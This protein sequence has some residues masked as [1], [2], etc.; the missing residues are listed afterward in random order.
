[1][2]HAVRR[3]QAGRFMLAAC[4]GALSLSWILGSCKS[5]SRPKAREIV[6]SPED[7]DARASDII[8]QA[9]E[10]AADNFGKLD[11]STTLFQPAATKYLY[12]QVSDAVKWS[13]QEHWLPVADSLFRFLGQARYYGL[14]PENYHLAQLASIRDRM[15]RDTGGR[16][17]RKDAVL[18]ARADLLST[19]AFFQLLHDIRLGRL[20]NDSVTLRADTV[21]TG[22]FYYKK[23]Q[24]LIQ[25]G[26]LRAMAQALEPDN[27]DYRALKDAIPAFLDSARFGNYTFLAYPYK[28]SAVFVRDLLHRLNEE[29]SLVRDPD[30]PVDSLELAR[31][32]LRY[33]KKRGLTPDGKFG[34]QVL[35]ALNN[36]DAEKFIRICISMDRYKK[37]P[38]HM[39][40]RYI[41]VNLPG[42][43]LEV[44][45][46]DSVVIQSRIV[47]GK[48]ATRT[49]VLTSSIYNMVTYPQ[50][51]IPTSII[52]KE[53][54]PGL[55]KDP[56]YLAK[57][58]YSLLDGKGNEVDPYFVDWSRYTRGIPYKVIQGSGDDN[59]LGVL[60]FN[61]GNKYAVY[62]HDT[63][64]RYLFSRAVRSLSHGCVRVQNWDQ[65]AGYILSCDSSAVFGARGRYL[66]SDTLRRW[67]E[68]KEKHTIVVHNRLPLYI[69]YITCVARDGKV[70]FYDD[71]YGED[72]RLRAYYTSTRQ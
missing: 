47:C 23:F 58:G 60:K 69:R 44:R 71:V 29:D 48:P 55:K 10:D 18:W 64:Q 31:Y 2:H 9:V 43:Y 67:L 49:P 54:L 66:P 15:A 28:D 8:S 50:W 38:A 24:E 40:D 3:F 70:S 27:A 26:S 35:N 59:A 34:Q 21:L 63:N 25:A 37:L 17:D 52:V 45:D 56:G 61:F 39:P 42:Y 11:D 16:E 62:L 12:D 1:M 7:I 22:A 72:R 68:R 53:I 14:L 36:T 46:S 6:T 32:L 57:K 20:P 51:T 19:D 33:Q 13:R 5:H 30:Q 4:L 41:W 65:V